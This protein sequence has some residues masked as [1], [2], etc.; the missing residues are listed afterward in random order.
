MKDVIERSYESYYG[1]LG[2]EKGRLSRELYDWIVNNSFAERVLIEGSCQG[3][4]SILLSRKG[5]NVTQA[6]I[7]KE[8][9]RYAESVIAREEH[10]I[11]KR[12]N[13]YDA[14][15]VGKNWSDQYDTLISLKKNVFL[16][17]GIHELIRESS[18][19]NFKQIIVVISIEKLIDPDMWTSLDLNRLMMNGMML[20]KFQSFGNYYLIV[21]FMKD[22]SFVHDD[23]IAR[24]LLAFNNEIIENNVKITIEKMT[25]ALEYSNSQINIVD[26]LKKENALIKDQMGKFITEIG[27]GVKDGSVNN[28][29]WHKLIDARL[30]RMEESRVADSRT[31]QQ[32]FKD[33]D[34]LQNEAKMKSVGL[35]NDVAKCLIEI[36]HIDGELSNLANSVQ[37]IQF[38]EKDIINVNE[39]VK[40]GLITILEKQKT[41]A[42]EITELKES[43]DKNNR[44][45][46]MTFEN[47]QSGIKNEAKMDLLVGSY[48]KIIREIELKFHKEIKEEERLLQNY[49]NLLKQQKKM[50]VKFDSIMKHPLG[51]LIIFSY[52]I[53]N[54]ITGKF[55][56]EKVPR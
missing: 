17:D 40:S 28:T 10:D 36:K 15:N 38:F 41:R 12:I 13:Y 47:I 56:K 9:S 11:G 19:F 1:F 34:R 5:I 53:Y 33:H 45:I 30:E 26:E 18:L 42:E 14:Q 20:E 8:L 24:S 7:D 55:N 44:I 6:E 43:L 37:R 25:K 16:I 52:E 48:Q 3:L 31:L 51:K 49:N 32:T 4:L 29:N 35:T 21:T 22:D 23:K 46:Q 39:S 27:N 54:K 2:P 50:E